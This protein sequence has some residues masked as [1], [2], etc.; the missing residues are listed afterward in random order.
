MGEWKGRR[1]DGDYS[2]FP[3]SSRRLAVLPY[4]TAVVRRLRR[5]IWAGANI[6]VQN[7]V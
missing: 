3:K 7:V 1:G 2:T 5:I 4:L 6:I